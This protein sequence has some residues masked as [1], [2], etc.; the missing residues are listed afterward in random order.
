MR[1][2]EG[3]PSPNCSTS[4]GSP[5]GACDKGAVRGLQGSWWEPG[6][7]GA[8]F[9]GKGWQRPGQWATAP[10]SHQASP[11]VSIFLA[12]ARLPSSASTVA[13]WDRC[14]AAS[15]AAIDRCAC[16]S[17]LLPLFAA[18]PPPPAPAAAPE[19]AALKPRGHQTSSHATAAGLE[20]AFRPPD[21]TSRAIAAPGL[22]LQRSCLRRATP[23]LLMV[24]DVRSTNSHV[25]NGRQRLGWH[26]PV[27][28]PPPPPPP[29][30]LISGAVESAI[31]ILIYVVEKEQSGDFKTPPLPCP[32]YRAARSGHPGRR[33]P[34]GAP[35]RPRPHL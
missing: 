17:V 15:H 6:R 9:G 35:S 32:A 34:R 27:S 33:R 23:A 7:G 26:H 19:A 2:T 25:P 22:L 21:S 1:P 31:Q 30:H 14:V 20:A 29:A 3:S 4:V 13:S 24:V 11:C 16:C 8:S 28:L 5:A 10:P 12:S 18:A